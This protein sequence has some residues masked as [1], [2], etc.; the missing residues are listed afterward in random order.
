M[1]IVTSATVSNSKKNKQPHHHTALSCI[2]NFENSTSEFNQ[3]TSQITTNTAKNIITKKR[4]CTFT[5]LSSPS[6]KNDRVVNDTNTITPNSMTTDISNT[7]QK[8]KRRKINKNY[9]KYTT[10][11]KTSTLFVP[12]EFPRTI[13]FPFH[14][15]YQMF[16][17]IQKE[18]NIRFKKLL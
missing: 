6:R 17:N 9:N 10:N 13:N 15:N 11:H 4:K 5:S 2:M 3:S 16:L 8:T 7:I 1:K 14:N 12:N 18:V